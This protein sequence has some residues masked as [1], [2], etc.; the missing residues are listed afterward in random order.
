M[1]A[2]QRGLGQC[3]P[4]KPLTQLGREGFLEEV[5]PELKPAGPVEVLAYVM[6]LINVDQIQ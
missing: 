1:R 6:P 3:V 4:R 2:G 5:V